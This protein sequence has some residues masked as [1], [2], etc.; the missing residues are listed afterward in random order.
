MD[1]LDEM[2]EV[3]KGFVGDSGVCSPE[4]AKKAINQA[5][6]LLYNKREWNTTC[7]YFAVCCADGC[8]TLP[9]RYEQIRLA[10]INKKPV[11]LADEWFN[12]TDSYA[13]ARH[14]QYSCHRQ[15]VEVGGRHTTFRDYTIHPFQISVMVENKA[16]AGV[17]LM[18]EAQDEYSTYHNITVAGAVAPEISK[19]TQLVRGIRSVS[20][21]ET[22]GRIRVYAYDPNLEARTLIAVYQ[23]DD[24][25]PSFRRFHIPRKVDCLT[26]Y[27]SKKFRDLTD[28]KELV[29]F[30]ADAMIYAVLALNSRENRNANEFLSNLALAIQEEEKAMEGDEIPTAAPLRIMNFSKADSLIG[31][32]LLSPSADDY[33]MHP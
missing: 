2:V 30:T 26:I 20:K 10:W 13:V 4:R 28:G 31:A 29:E 6:R 11:S 5:R 24:V 19:S 27:A 25:N 32:D 16:D 9:D 23:P 3:V 8:L 1:T 22:K 18:F 14:P 15:V 21:P 7:E 17:E 33:F 12:S